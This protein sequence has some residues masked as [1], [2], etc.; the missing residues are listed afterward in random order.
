MTFGNYYFAGQPITLVILVLTAIALFAALAMVVVS[1]FLKNAIVPGIGCG[2]LVLGALVIAVVGI[3]AWKIQQA[4]VYEA[5]A[6]ADPSFQKELV[7]EGMKE[8][9]EPLMMGVLGAALPGLAG[10]GLGLLALKRR[11]ERT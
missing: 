11:A 4:R 10:L 2:V 9:Q 3:G 8:S 6:M 1:M 5:A 7:D